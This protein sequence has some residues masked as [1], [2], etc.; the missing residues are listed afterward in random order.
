MSWGAFNRKYFGSSRAYDHC[1]GGSQTHLMAR[2]CNRYFGS[3]RHGCWLGAML[4]A[5]RFTSI[6]ASWLRTFVRCAVPV[7]VYFGFMGALFAQCAVCFVLVSKA[8]Y[9]IPEGW[10]NGGDAVRA[11]LFLNAG[12]ACS[13][14][15]WFFAAA[16]ELG[17][18]AATAQAHICCSL[19]SVDDQ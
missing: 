5:L 2:R 11:F 13:V 4:L 1:S 19:C 14:A 6:H 9:S 15:K 3:F 7:F 18:N 16:R 8:G 12:T 17:F 10:Q